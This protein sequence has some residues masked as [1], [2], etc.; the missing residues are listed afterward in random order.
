MSVAEVGEFPISSSVR[1]ADILIETVCED[2]VTP[3]DFWRSV[4]APLTVSERP[5]RSST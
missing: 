5:K 3:S 1:P 4:Y 2:N